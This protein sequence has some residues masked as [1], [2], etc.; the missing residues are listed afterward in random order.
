[1]IRGKR[2][3]HLQSRE[4]IG[5]NQWPISEGNTIYKMEESHFTFICTVQH[6][7]LKQEPTPIHVVINNNFFIKILISIKIQQLNESV[8]HCNNFREFV[9]PESHFGR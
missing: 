9:F 5:D 6:H 4:S 1:M 7:P 2:R 8:T 3:E